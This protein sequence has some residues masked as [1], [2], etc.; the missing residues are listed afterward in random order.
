MQQETFDGPTEINTIPAIDSTKLSTTSG[1]VNGGED[2]VRVDKSDSRNRETIHAVPPP[3]HC[4]DARS[5]LIQLPCRKTIYE[6][7]MTD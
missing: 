2:D 5:S 1:M 3:L 7:R 6:Y 4:Y